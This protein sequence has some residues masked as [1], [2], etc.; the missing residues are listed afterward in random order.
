MKKA[1]LI[2]GGAAAAIILI[3]NLAPMIGLAIGLAVL[4]YAAKKFMK[5]ESAWGK[6]VW[7]ILGLIAIAGSIS[8]VPAL[9]GVAAAYVLYLIWKNWN[10]A[11]EDKV[12][13]D[14]FVNFEKEWARLK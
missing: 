2:A 10:R 9:I 8:N 1:G 14:P 4:Y 13:N 11:K 6:A 12:E 5:A 7:G 3:A